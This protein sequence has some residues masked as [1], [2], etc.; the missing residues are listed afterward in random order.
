MTTPWL[1]VV[2]EYVQAI[3]M[4]FILAMIIRA[5]LIQSFFIPSGSMLNTLL[6]G[7][8]LLVSRIVYGVTVPFTNTVLLR[9]AEPGRGDVVVFRNPMNPA[10]DDFIKRIVG[11]PGDRIEI[12]DKVV[13][14]NGEKLDEPYVRHT[15]PDIRP[16]RRD[17]L[18]QFTVPQDS[19][20]CMGD[21]RDESYDSRFWG[22]VPRNTIRGKAWIIYG[23]WPEFSLDG[24]TRIRWERTGNLVR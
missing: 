1:T 10:D 23:S 14:V 8:H 13:Y 5:F 11:T 16:G 22:F 20:F 24:L 21:N 12:R 6:I 15:D 18:A 2:K 19:Y 4:A 3:V 9:F 17:N 7:D